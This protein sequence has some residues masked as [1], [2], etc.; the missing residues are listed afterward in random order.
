[1]PSVGGITRPRLLV[2]FDRVGQFVDINSWRR[3]DRRKQT[4]AG[5][6]TVKRY[7]AYNRIQDGWAGRP[8]H[9]HVAAAAAGGLHLADLVTHF[10][11]AQL[12]GLRIPQHFDTRHRCASLAVSV[13]ATASVS[14][15]F[16]DVLPLVPG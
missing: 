10:R 11:H 16:L 4:T 6:G 3:A 7:R 14:A 2:V 15:P 13:L 8:Y 12:S 1:M 9:E 5:G